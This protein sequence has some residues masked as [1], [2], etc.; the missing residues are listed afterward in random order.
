MDNKQAFGIYI[1]IPFCISKCNYCN[2]VSKCD[3]KENIEKYINYLCEQI[4]L[5]SVFFADKIATSIYFGGGTPSFINEKLIEKV[6]K[7]LKKCLKIDKNAEINIEC[8]PNS[9]SKQ[10]LEHYK[11]IGINRISF[12]IQSLN[13]EC[14]KI[15]GR[16]HSRN[17]ALKIIHLAQEVGFDNISADLLIGIPNQTT[18]MLKS[19]IKDLINA[20]VKHISA[21][22]L[23]LEKGT[24][25]YEQV[26]GGLLQVASE[27]DS[28]NM[29]KCS[30]DKLKQ[31]G[32]KRYEISNFALPGYECK[33]NINYWDM[34]EYVGFG[35]A[36]HSYFN[37]TR[38]SGIENFKDYYKF[39]EEL[40]FKTNSIKNNEIKQN[41]S[42]FN[43]IYS[44]FNKSLC[45][46]LTK[47]QIIE[48]TIMLGLRQAK[49]VNLQKLKALGLDLQKEKK[50]QIELLLKNNFIKIE[51]D[52][53]FVTE[54]NFGLVSAIIL[55]LI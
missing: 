16:K 45:E 1:H 13:D 43:E 3:S 14:L 7:T 20:G 6:L 47:E 10:K 31:Y 54:Q 27:D 40:K 2:F 19:D 49:G 37:G 29:Y 33:H 42:N 38:Y 48:E 52:Y 32:F 22:M 21:Y 26:K 24:I 36:A 41:Y 11:N 50:E 17:Q 39:V 35:L 25:L 18:K 53:L 55:E 51:N 28:V 9:A 4:E 44:N 12:G 30:Y 23:I 34:G 46:N 8:N 5:Q 15:I